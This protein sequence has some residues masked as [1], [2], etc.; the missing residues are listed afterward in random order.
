MLFLNYYLLFFSLQ[1][2]KHFPIP[3][4]V[5]SLWHPIPKD[6]YIHTFTPDHMLRSAKDVFQPPI[7][8]PYQHGTYPA[9]TN[10]NIFILPLSGFFVILQPKSWVEL[11]YHLL[12]SIH[13]FISAKPKYSIIKHLDYE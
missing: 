11:Q 8:L 3:P 7:P 10:V 9:E 4:K 13:Y 1:R 6:D 12:Q 2:Y 5:R